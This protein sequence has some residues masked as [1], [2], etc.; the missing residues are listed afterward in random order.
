LLF[1]RGTHVEALKKKAMDELHV[2]QEEHG[3]SSEFFEQQWIRQREIQLSVMETESEKEML[4]QIEELV[5]LEDK[6][7]ETKCVLLVVYSC[8]PP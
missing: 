6:L 8:L 7:R 1:E 2:L 4:K 5:E 3:H